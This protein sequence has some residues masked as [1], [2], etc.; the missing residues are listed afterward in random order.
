MEEVSEAEGLQAYCSEANHPSTGRCLR[1]DRAEMGPHPCSCFWSSAPYRTSIFYWPRTSRPNTSIGGLSACHRLWALGEH[2]ATCLFHSF[3]LSPPPRA[4]LPFFWSLEIQIILFHSFTAKVEVPPVNKN[5][6]STYY[7]L[8]PRQDTK[9]PALVE[10]KSS[11]G[12]R[13]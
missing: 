2:R 12:Q 6:L 3:Y 7:L 9:I 5:L 11:E 10:L 4:L 8:I 1:N 13:K